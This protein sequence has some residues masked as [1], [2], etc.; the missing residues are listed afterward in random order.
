VSPPTKFEA[1]D[2]KATKR[3]LAEIAGKKLSSFPSAPVE[4]TLTR[5]VSPRT[6]SRTKTSYLKF[7]SPST[8]F[9]ALSEKATKRP[10]A[11]IETD[12]FEEHPEQGFPLAPAE[13]TLTRVVFTATPAEAGTA[14]SAKAEAVS[15]KNRCLDRLICRSPSLPSCLEDG[16]R[17]YARVRGGVEDGGLFG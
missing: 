10:L 17:A 2:A 11:E 5:V 3:P 9:G 7:R 16:R 6:R 4:P 15:A 12:E 1:K 8:R 14:V 13:F